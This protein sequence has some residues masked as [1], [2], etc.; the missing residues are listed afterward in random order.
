MAGYF[1]VDEYLR[2]SFD[3]HEIHFAQPTNEAEDV[4]VFE[5]PQ[6]QLRF[7]RRKKIGEDKGPVATSFAPVMLEMTM[8]AKD[9]DLKRISAGTS[10]L[11]PSYSEHYDRSSDRPIMRAGIVSSDPESNYQAAGDEPARRIL[12]QAHSAEGASGGPVF[13]LHN[14]EGML[15]GVNGGHLTGREQ[16]IGTIH[17]G[18]SFCFK[19]VCVQECIEAIFKERP[20]L[21]TEVQ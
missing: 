20:N 9:E 2:V 13:A 3:G 10:I 6:G 12:Y 15:V 4:F 16:K 17:S 8:L 19:A 7:A 11:L 1:N 18:F 21:D 5:V 14:N